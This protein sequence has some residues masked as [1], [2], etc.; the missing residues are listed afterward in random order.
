MERQVRS[1][2]GSLAIEWV[3]CVKLAN[4]HAPLKWHV[5]YYENK[6]IISTHPSGK[7]L[8]LLFKIFNYYMVLTKV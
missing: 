3:S 8:K 2:K 4:L 5:V 7:H 1:G 6:K